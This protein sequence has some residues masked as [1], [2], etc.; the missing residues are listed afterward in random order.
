MDILKIGLDT[1]ILIKK[2]NLSYSKVL[3]TGEAGDINWAA[4][5]V[6]N[7]RLPFNIGHVRESEKHTAV[8]RILNIFL[9]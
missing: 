3:N 6:L 2:G 9:K 4:F 8:A 5:S 1:Y 7:K